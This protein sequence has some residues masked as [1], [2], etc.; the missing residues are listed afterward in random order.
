MNVGIV[1]TRISQSKNK[2][3]WWGVQQDDIPKFVVGDKILVNVTKQNNQVYQGIGEIHKINGKIITL[4]MV[5]EK[6]NNVPWKCISD[7]I[8]IK[9]VKDTTTMIGFGESHYVI[10]HFKIDEML[11]ACPVSIKNKRLRP[12]QC[13]CECKECVV[14]LWR[15]QV[16]KL[17]KKPKI[18]NLHKNNKLNIQH[19]M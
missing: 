6:L 2:E 7:I 8:Q 19:I 9:Y 18:K 14:T 13:S 15:K 17:E 11:G 3:K 16:A 4:K 10:S 1:G 5:S 12:E